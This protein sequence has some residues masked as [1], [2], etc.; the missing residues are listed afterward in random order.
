MAQM[1]E[2][3]RI[4]EKELSDAEIASLSDAEFKTLVV[5]MLK[6][7]VEYGKRIREEMVTQ[8]EIKKNPQEANSEGKEAGLQI[9]IWN[10]RNNQ[11]EQ[12]EETRI[13]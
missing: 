6:D 4:P 8:S 1:K 12:K 2:Q 13:F 9:K 7:L 10:L 11:P 5:R 3:K